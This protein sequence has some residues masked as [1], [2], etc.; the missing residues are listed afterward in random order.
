MPP[1]KRIMREFRID[2]I[3]GVDNPAQ[4]GARVAVMKR[5]DG[6]AQ[7]PCGRLKRALATWPTC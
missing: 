4:E 3:S 2:E 5:D 1:R 7:S 6:E